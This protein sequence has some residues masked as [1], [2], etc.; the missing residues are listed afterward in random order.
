MKSLVL[1]AAGA[2]AA[3]SLAAAADLPVR[4]S[5]DVVPLVPAFTWSG[6]YVGA[7]AGYLWGRD[8][9]TEYLTST[10]A[11][12]GYAWKEKLDSG[13][14]G[15]HAG[16]NQQFG[17]FVAGVEV[18][19][20]RLPKAKGGFDDPGGIGRVRRSWNFSAR[21]RLGV[22]F[23]RVLIYATGGYAAT[24]ARYVYFNPAVGYGEGFAKTLSGYTLG[25]G[26]EY[27][28]TDHLTAR[29]E[30]R[31]ADYRK[32]TYVA[33]SAFAG[34]TGKQEP[35]DHSVRLGVSYKF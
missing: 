22:A 28:I 11:F 18:D 32:T 30:Y 34:L 8:K 33:A 21:G 16:Y 27:A 1:A 5:V 17:M 10:G 25:A 3:T 19:A 15:L 24:R 7:Q 9:T 2:L 6:F 23:D 4:K 12:T 29:L 13:F 14:A 35:R 31:F 26:V 20:D